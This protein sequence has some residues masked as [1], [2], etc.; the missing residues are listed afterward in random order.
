MAQVWRLKTG[1]RTVAFDDNGSG[2]GA[3]AAQNSDVIDNSTGLWSAAWVDVEIGFGLGPSV[4]HVHFSI[5][6][7]PDGTNYSD[8][9][10]TAFQERQVAAISLITGSSNAHRYW[11]YIDNLP[12]CK[13]KLRY[14]NDPIRGSDQSIWGYTPVTV[15]LVAA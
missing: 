5:V 4:S 1:G 6:E 15:E 8:E 14:Y 13:F 12:P 11:F 7:S 3:G 10:D 9:T 2:V